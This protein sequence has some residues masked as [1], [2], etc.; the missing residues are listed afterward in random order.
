MTS[1]T[2][3]GGYT[4]ATG[5]RMKMSRS[6]FDLSARLAWSVFCSTSSQTSQHE[7]F[8]QFRIRLLSIRSRSRARRAA[9]VV[10]SSRIPAPSFRLYVGFV[11]PARRR[12]RPPPTDGRQPRTAT[13]TEREFLHHITRRYRSHRVSPRVLSRRASN[14]AC[15]TRSQP[16]GGTTTDVSSAAPASAAS[17]R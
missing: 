10:D 5:G 4:L 3:P 16:W 14:R 7:M 1:R 8:V 13:R 12:V 6:R 15:T 2:R 17:P 9:C 11:S